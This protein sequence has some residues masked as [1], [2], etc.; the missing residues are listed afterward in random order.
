MSKIPETFIIGDRENMTVESLLKILEDMYRQLAVAVNRKPDINKRPS[1]GQ[2]AD[3]FLSDG[4]ININQNTF[5][6]EI[7]TS[8]P[9]PQTVTWKTI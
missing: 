3:V 4:D 7:L 8:H 6:I 2:T 5:K 9:T 1:D